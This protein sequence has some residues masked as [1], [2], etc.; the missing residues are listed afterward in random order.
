M[1]GIILKIVEFG[2]WLYNK[3]KEEPDKLDI[4]IEG[5]KNNPEGVSNDKKGYIS[6]IARKHGLTE[7]E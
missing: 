3:Y 6:D 4:V 1:T 5:I 7:P 2:V